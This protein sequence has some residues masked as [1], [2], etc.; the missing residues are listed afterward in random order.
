MK[1]GAFGSVVPGARFGTSR[2]VS[3]R[4][5]CVLK[6]DRLFSPPDADHRKRAVSTG[7]GAVVGLADLKGCAGSHSV[8]AG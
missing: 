8:F 5:S 4:K 6:P 7:K 3:V 2:C 1:V